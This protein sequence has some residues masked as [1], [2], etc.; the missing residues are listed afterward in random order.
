M[1]EPGYA[2][3]PMRVGVQ[4]QPQSSSY[5]EILA[6]RGRAGGVRRGRAVQLGPLL[7]RVRPRGRQAR[8]VLDDAGRWSAR[9]G[10][11][12][13]TTADAEGSAFRDRDVRRFLDLAPR[14][15]DQALKLADQHYTGSH[16]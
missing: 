10:Q 6:R 3:Y 14:P 12:G 4:T 2:K 16:R 8:R 15:V 11:S 5:S 9:D 1:T 13:P 7:P